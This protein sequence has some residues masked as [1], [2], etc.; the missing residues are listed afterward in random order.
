MTIPFV[1]AQPTDI[2]PLPNMEAAQGIPLPGLQAA[3][4]AHTEAIREHAAQLQK[5]TSVLKDS[6]KHF[7]AREKYI[8]DRAK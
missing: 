4:E 7:A 6:N 2:A 3:L 5:L 1:E 8:K